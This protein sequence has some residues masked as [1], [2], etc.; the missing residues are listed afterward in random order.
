MERIQRHFVVCLITGLITILPIGGTVLLII[1]AERSLSPLIPDKVYFP[2]GGLLVVIVL[3]YLLGLMLTSVIGRWIWDSLDCGL[4]RL[5]G[6]GMLYRTLKQILGFDAGEGA[7]FQRVVLVPDDSTNSMEIGLV[8]ATEGDGGAKQLIVFV[9]C[10]PNPSQGR[11][12]RI[13]A[14]RV[15]PTDW[16]VDKALK[17]LFS[18]GKI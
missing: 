15:A 10:S 9:P 13:P 1:F 6:L 18:L 8:T 5:P 7:L 3:L 14:S 11:L 12:L 16:S 17:S 4:S 2:G